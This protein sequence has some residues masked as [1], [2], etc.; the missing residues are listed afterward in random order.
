MGVKVNVTV[1]TQHIKIDDEQIPVEWNTKEGRF[2]AE[3]RNR[4]FTGPNPDSIRAEI[5]SVRDE[6]RAKMARARVLRAAEKNPTPAMLLPNLTPV[7]VRGIDRRTGY[8]LILV[9]GR[10]ESVPSWQL[11]RPLTDAEAQDV[12]DAIQARRD[13]A[14]ALRLGPQPITRR[15]AADAVTAYVEAHYD[16][17]RGVFAAVYEGE[18]FEANGIYNLAV[19]IGAYI[20]RREWPYS[21]IKVS[22]EIIVVSVEDFLA[23]PGH[24]L[25]DW[26]S[27]GLFKTRE[28]AEQR[29]ALSA[30]FAKAKDD[31]IL[32]LNKYRL[33]LSM[34]ED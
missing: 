3:W 24:I 30:A 12:H 11:M 20:T 2:R 5:S 7:G 29:V 26:G 32:T 22:D 6:E 18:L 1:D 34:F 13:A 25:S 10:R 15:R 17:D 21:L 4:T 33:D 8:P 23:D 19:S 27:G 14:D 16:A 31:E 9:D 28:D